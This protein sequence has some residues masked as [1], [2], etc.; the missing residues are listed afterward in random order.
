MDENPY[1]APQVEPQEELHDQPEH[2]NWL[3]WDD[4]QKR[5]NWLRWGVDRLLLVVFAS[6]AFILIALLLLAVLLPPIY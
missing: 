3:S 4:L 2:R 6:I 1:K 5:R